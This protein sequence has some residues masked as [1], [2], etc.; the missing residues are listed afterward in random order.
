[1]LA[2]ACH[3]A[4]ALIWQHQSANNV[5]EYMN[6]LKNMRKVIL[7]VMCE[8]SFLNQFIKLFF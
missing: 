4:T 2:Q 3:A 8:F 1:M 6:D 5:L 7:Q